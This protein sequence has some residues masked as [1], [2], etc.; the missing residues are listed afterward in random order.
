MLL[1]SMIANGAEQ[2]QSLAAITA[3]AEKFVIEMSQQNPN[4]EL[5]INAAPLDPRLK[6]AACSQEITVYAPPGFRAMGN[7]NVGVR[8]EGT[9]RWNILIPVNVRAFT[10]VLVTTHP[11]SRG[12]PIVAND[13][14]LAKRE[15]SNL[16]GGFFTSDAEIIGQVTNQPLMM[17]TILSRNSVTPPLLVRR[18]EQVTIIASGDGIEI[19]SEGVAL[20]NGVLGST[21]TVSNTNS[22]RQIEGIVT[23]P[24]MIQVKI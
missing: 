13:I 21:V 4:I 15:I 14:K 11:L 23:A 22:K 18:G 24:G 16:T 20:Q 12:T 9:Q 8:C 5:E 7:S 10:N 3:A 6:L 19:R 1:S 2:T 17:E